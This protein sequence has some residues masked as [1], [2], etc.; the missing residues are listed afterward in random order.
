MNYSKL[1]KEIRAIIR[2]KIWDPYFYVSVKLRKAYETS[3]NRLI[4]GEK[5]YLV[6][7]YGCGV[8]PYEY[9]FKGHTEKYVGVDLE[10]N[11]SADIKIN[12]GDKLPLS[13]KSFD[14]VISSQVLEH[15]IDVDHYLNECNRVLKEEGYMLLS[16]HGTWQ[17]H[18]SPHD[19]N[20]W[21]W[22]GLKNLL[23][24]HDF[25]I[26]RSIPILGQLA[27]SSQLRLSFYNSFARMLGPLGSFLL[28]PISLLYQIKMAVEDLVTPKRVKGRDSAI[29][30][31][32]AKKRQNLKS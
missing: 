3:I 6:L 24:H 5:R 25:E 17:Y 20:R 27:V 12:P 15:V 2:P 1:P 30:L 10:S 29:Y 21:T 19:Y 9:I 22:D 28:F 13:N 16:T 26:V 14:F 32:I 8:K 4:E 23:E 11:L 31:A 7:D 18:S